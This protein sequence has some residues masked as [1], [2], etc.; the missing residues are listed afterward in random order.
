MRM[1][2]SVIRRLSVEFT[3]SSRAKLW[4][5]VTEEVRQ[6]LIDAYV[7]DQIYTASLSITSGMT[8]KEIIKFRDEVRAAIRAR[9]YG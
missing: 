4:S 9:F 6:D 3:V 2:E 7:M 1:D 5:F 8:P